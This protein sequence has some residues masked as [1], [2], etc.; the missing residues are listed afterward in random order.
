[1]NRDIRYRDIIYDFRSDYVTSPNR[2]TLD[3][4]MK[5]DPTTNSFQE[6]MARLSGHK[7]S[8]LVISGAMG[9]QAALRQPFWPRRTASFAIV[10][11]TFLGWK[12]GDLLRFMAH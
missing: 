4:V 1:M 6:F 2:A 9:N 11:A 7:D 12:R 8:L 3:N 5:E 10:E